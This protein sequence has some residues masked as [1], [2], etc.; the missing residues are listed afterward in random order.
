VRRTL[1]RTAV[2]LVVVGLTSAFTSAP[3]APAWQQVNTSGFA[4]PDAVEVAALEV[5]DG[6]LYAGTENPIDGARIFRS[7]DGN[8]WASVIE[9]G[10]GIMHDHR[11]PAIIAFEVYNGRLY[12]GTGWGDQRGQLWRTQD[13]TTW[14]PMEIA[15]F[16][17]PD[18]KHIS[19]LIEYNGM[20]YAGAGNLITGA[21]VWRSYSGENNT[22]TQV[23]PAVPGAGPAS[24][25]GFAVYKAAL[26]AAVE[27]ESPAQIWRFN[28]A[29]W[30]VVIDDGFGDSQTTSTGSLTEFAGYLY[31]GAGHQNDGA[32]L[33]RTQDGDIWQ[34]AITPGFGNPNNEQVESVFVYQ[35][36]IYA[37]VKNAQTGME[38]WRSS[39][40]THWEQANV[41]GFGDSNNTGSNRS[42]A[43][44]E[45]G[46]LLYVGT[47]NTVDGG[48]VWRMLQTTYANAFYLPLVLR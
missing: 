20:L 14:T 29:A 45:F 27:S 13:G 23:A 1:V 6:Y 37:G 47:S 9:P 17:D 12:A 7:P 3:N 48:E 41:G 46:S 30:E 33:W 25:S 43:V 34:Q 10:F 39:D 4:D 16:G 44:A 31:L 26:Y 2:L 28:G 19:A 32:Q 36:Q 5:F 38:I 11:P 35:N 40:G 8:T 42:S 21:Q 18:T 15:G 24:I 22:W